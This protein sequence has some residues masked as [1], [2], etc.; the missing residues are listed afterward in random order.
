M[1]CG[2]VGFRICY[3]YEAQGAKKLYAIQ[4]S[5]IV[6]GQGV[7]SH[8]LDSDGKRQLTQFPIPIDKKWT[9]G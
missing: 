2:M 3:S 1:E 4:V 5:S 9:A 7:L 6:Q 8:M